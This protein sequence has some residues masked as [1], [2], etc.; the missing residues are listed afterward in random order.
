MEKVNVILIVVVFVLASCFESV[1]NQI[2]YPWR[3]CPAI[4]LVGK[5]IN[6]LYDNPIDLAI[7]SVILEGPYNR[8][9]LPVDII[10]K[11][12]F[13]YDAFTKAA[14]N[15]TI[16][17]TI[18]EGTPEELY[19]LFIKSGGETNVSKRSVKVL[20]SYYNP[21]RFI[22]ITDPHISRQWIGMPDNG[23][24]K[25]LE[26]LDKFIE[27]AN[28]IHPEYI[29]V[30]G[31]IIH[32][33][34]RYDAD[35]L[36]WGGVVRSGFEHPPLAEEKYKNYF[37]GAKGLSGVY[38]F[39]APVFSLPGNHDFYG[40]KIDDHPAKA[41]QWNRLMGKRVYGFSYMDT[42]FIAAD[43]YL[44]DSLVDIPD[45]APMSGLQGMALDSFLNMAGPG[46]LRIMAEHRQNRVDTAFVDRNKINILLM[47]NIHTPSQGFVGTTPTL[48]IRPGVVCRSGE[49]SRWEKTLGFFRIFTIDGDTFQYSQP[50]RFCKNP[51][52]SYKQLV[53]NLTL[54]FKKDNYGRSKSNEAV[55]SNHFDIPLSDCHIRFIM[56]KNKKE[57]KV[58]GGEIYQTIEN[59][60][61]LVVDVRT[62]VN[63]KSLRIVKIE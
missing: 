45:K 12:R 16:R 11:G 6:I 56:S 29:I 7:D 37:E 53:L 41:A 24:A 49:I 34:T 23:Y 54:D 8:V 15:N 36:G 22:H 39:N 63:A 27:V 19:D 43:D 28:I 51:T 30:T 57:Y 33:Y 50:L 60:H 21:H 38:G 20:K 61:F 31:D 4:V 13:E 32:D 26:L 3:A 44:G 10:R 55:L 35:S 2:V 48:I 62:D 14:V 5:T 9:V 1:A 59:S 58:S 52:A 47:G 46:K 42:R 40:P 18:P 17:V 25:E